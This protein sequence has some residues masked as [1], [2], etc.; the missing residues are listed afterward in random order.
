MT[1]SNMYAFGDW[2]VDGI[3]CPIR[4]ADTESP[5]VAEIV[6][7]DYDDRVQVHP[8]VNTQEGV[9]DA[10]IAKETFEQLADMYERRLHSRSVGEDPSLGRESE[11]DSKL[12]V[13]KQVLEEEFDA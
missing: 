2:A 6:A 4:S 1:E 11:Y 7:T 12:D 10:E 3:S 9:V 5:N 13:A 8:K